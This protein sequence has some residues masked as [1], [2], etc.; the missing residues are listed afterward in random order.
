MSKARDRFEAHFDLDRVGL[1]GLHYEPGWTRSH[2]IDRARGSSLARVA[3]V[4]PLGMEFPIYFVAGYS[5]GDAQLDIT[6]SS[7]I[8]HELAAGLTG[9]SVTTV[10]NSSL[11]KATGRGDE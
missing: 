1:D 6:L 4:M 7:D 3:V 5:D 10:W 11:W 2:P 9:A 8:A